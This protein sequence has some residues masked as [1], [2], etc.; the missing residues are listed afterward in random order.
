[1]PDR[2]AILIALCVAVATA[3]TV[4]VLHADCQNEIGEHTEACSHGHHGHHHH[5]HDH[6]HGD[7]D[8][9]HHHESDHDHD[10]DRHTSDE[11]KLYR[12]GVTSPIKP[13]LAIAWAMPTPIATPA[14]VQVGLRLD[15]T[16]TRAGPAPGY[17]YIR[18]FVLLV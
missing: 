10:H 8:H 15:A 11:L 13:L 5:H 2:M 4:Q 12:A 7:A 6:D 18:T 17:A 16:P 9:E 3:G 14:D 1:M